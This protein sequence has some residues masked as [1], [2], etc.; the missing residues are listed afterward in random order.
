M[1]T[2][3]ASVAASGVRLS[4]RVALDVCH[5]E[6]HDQIDVSDLHCIALY[7]LLQAQACALKHPQQHKQES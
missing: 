7:S 4:P 1:Q 2:R 3:N 6:P 5:L